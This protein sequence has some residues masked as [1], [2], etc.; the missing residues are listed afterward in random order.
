LNGNPLIT[1]EVFKASWQMVDDNLIRCA[2]EQVEGLG[3]TESTIEFMMVAGLPDSA[4]PFLS[5]DYLAEGRIRSVSEMFNVS[6]SLSGYKAMALI[7]AGARS[8]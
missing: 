7:A 5:F 2:R 3:F 1:P 4:A 8:A 6:P